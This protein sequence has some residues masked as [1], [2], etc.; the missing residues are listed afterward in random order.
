MVKYER[1]KS[2]GATK[3]LLKEGLCGVSSLLCTAYAL[4]CNEN[5]VIDTAL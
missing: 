3:M 5:H 2:L 1:V 4:S